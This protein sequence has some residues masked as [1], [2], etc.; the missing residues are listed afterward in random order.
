MPQKRAKY[1]LPEDFILHFPCSF[2]AQVQTTACQG[3]TQRAHGGHGPLNFQK[4][5]SDYCTLHVKDPI[6]LYICALLS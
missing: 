1:A 2:L 5:P 3:V 6:K 4:I